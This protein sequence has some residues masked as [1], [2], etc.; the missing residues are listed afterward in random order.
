ML[1]RDNAEQPMRS[2]LH[3]QWLWH[4][5][6]PEHLPLYQL[7]ADDAR[8]AARMIC[9]HQDIAA[10]SCFALGML[11]GFDGIEAEPW[12][13]RELFWECGMIGQALYLEAEAAGVRATGIGC[14]FDDEMHR[15]LGL[16]G[17]AWQSLYHFTVGGPVEDRRLTTLPPYAS[18][19]QR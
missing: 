2:A 6:G 3:A 5:A 13:Y 4:K 8:D 12:R 1:L 11:A 16:E 9:C 19:A 15:L 17:N 18:R 10:D 7:A 14:F